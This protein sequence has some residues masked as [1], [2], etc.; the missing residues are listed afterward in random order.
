M[1]SHFD[2]LKP[3]V[4]IAAPAITLLIA[5]LLNIL[6]VA[7]GSNGSP[8]KLPGGQGTYS[9]NFPLTE[10]PISED[11]NWVNNS[12]GENPNVRTTPGYAFGTWTGAS[13]DPIAVFAK[14]AWVANQSAEGVVKINTAET[15]CCHEVEMHLRMSTSGSPPH[16]QGYEINCS[17]VASNPYVQIVEWNSDLTYAYIA[18][19]SKNYCHNGDMFKATIVGSRITAYIN[20]TQVLQGT[21]STYSSGSPGFGF[22]ESES[23]VNYFGFSS[24]T[25]DGLAAK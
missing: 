7:C 4:S 9:T 17:V 12:S 23:N 21:D 19:Q 13:G 18:Q 14:G 24:F 8:S 5:L 16:Y 25:A 20:G 10:N 22:Y 3:K 1:P 15:S 6:P 2:G 11:G